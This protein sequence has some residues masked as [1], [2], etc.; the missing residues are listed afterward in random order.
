[1]FNDIFIFPAANDSGTTVGAAAWVYEHVLG[2][3]MKN[4]RLRNVYLG[5]EYNDEEVKKVVERGKWSA[6]YVG[7]DVNEVVDLVLKGHVVAWYQGRAELGP[8]ALGNRSIVADPRRREM[9]GIVN[10]IKGR[11][12]WRP[13]PHRSSWRTWRSTSSIPCRTSS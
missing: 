8:R 2:E 4:V 9:W 13:L 6:R 10:T 12:W 1:V 5:P 3:K 7:E 11:E